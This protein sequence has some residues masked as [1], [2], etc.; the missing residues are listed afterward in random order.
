MAQGQYLT[1]ENYNQMNKKFRLAALV[2]LM[3]GLIGGGAL[4]AVGVAKSAKAKEATETVIAAA[5]ERLDEIN[6]EKTA[7]ESQYDSKQNECSSLKMG[8]DDWFSA[9]TKCNNEA[10]AI[11]SKIADLEQEQFKLKN[12]HYEP[13]Q[14]SFFYVLGAFCII[15]GLMVSFGVFMIT[16]R[17]VLLA[18]SVQTVMP[19]GKEVVEKVTPTAAKAAGKVAESV[20]EGIKKGKNS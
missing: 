8:T 14:Y 17:R 16:K 9:S 11:K 2:I 4:I 6:I 20:A 10:L 7:L 3:V 12:A 1:E 15:A 5:K 13:E 18:H 19:V